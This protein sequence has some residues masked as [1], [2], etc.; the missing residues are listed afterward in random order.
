MSDPGKRGQGNV[1][2]A[3]RRRVGGQGAGRGGGQDRGQS[4]GIGKGPAPIAPK[5]TRKREKVGKRSD[6]VYMMAGGYVRQAV[7]ERVMEVLGNREVRRA[8]FEELDRYG[9]RHDGKRVYYGDLAELMCLQ[10]LERLG[11][12]VE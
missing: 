11:V 6:P 9:V 5:R 12:E 8:L 1:A 3:M 2:D 7:H 10:W 4:G